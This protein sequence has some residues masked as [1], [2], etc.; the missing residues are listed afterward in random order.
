MWIS[1]KE[2]K[3]ERSSTSWDQGPFCCR[4]HFAH[5]IHT[6]DWWGVGSSY[7][8]ENQ[9]EPETSE[10]M[11]AIVDWDWEICVVPNQIVSYVLCIKP[12]REY[13]GMHVKTG[14]SNVAINSLNIL[15]TRLFLGTPPQGIQK[16][17][18]LTKG[19]FDLEPSLKD[20]L[21]VMP[22]LAKYY[23]EVPA[24]RKGVVYWWNDNIVKL[25]ELTG[26]DLIPINIRGYY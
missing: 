12:H 17:E 6:G 16:F 5:K 14:S 3:T 10:I 22:Y 19:C 26:E 7:E 4:H 24:E 18:N 15:L 9:Y 11:Q 8:A 1:D 2:A 21:Q 20:T 25:R 23:K 13:V